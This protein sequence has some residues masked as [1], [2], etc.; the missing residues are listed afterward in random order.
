MFHT[1]L[2]WRT[3]RWGEVGGM[4]LPTHSTYSSLGGPLGIKSLGKSRRSAYLFLIMIV[5]LHVSPPVPLTTRARSQIISA[6]QVLR[7]ELQGG[8]HCWS[9]HAVPRLRHR[10]AGFGLDDLRGQRCRLDVVSRPRLHC[11]L[12]GHL[13]RLPKGEDDLIGLR[14]CGGKK[15]CRKSVLKSNSPPDIKLG[16]S[17]LIKVQH[18][19]LKLVLS[20]TKQRV[21]Q[22]VND[23]ITTT[24]NSQLNRVCFLNSILQWAWKP[25]MLG[26]NWM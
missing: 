21:V 26:W 22:H 7:E 19:P 20:D 2:F 6:H 13:K 14:L 8:T 10:A 9:P 3:K 23:T 15:Y 16:Q 5:Q 25:F 11:H 1:C 12:I 18:Q 17:F 24:H 4:K